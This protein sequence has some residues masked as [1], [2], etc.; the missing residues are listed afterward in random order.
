MIKYISQSSSVSFL[1]WLFNSDL[2]SHGVAV[3]EEVE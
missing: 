3:K 2:T 1:H